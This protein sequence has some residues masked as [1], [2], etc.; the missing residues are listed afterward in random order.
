[1][2]K[3]T[4][5]A[6]ITGIYGQDGSY[7]CEILS[8]LGYLVYG[9][10]KENLSKNSQKIKKYLENKNI[11]PIVYNTDLNNLEELQK[12]LIEINPDE[13]YHLAA[14]HNS[15]ENT[16]DEN[17]SAILN[18]K[19]LYDYNTKS[20][21]NILYIATEFLKSKVVIAGSC[22]MFD[23][24][25]TNIQNENTPFCSK[26][27][28]GLAKISEYELAQYYR[29]KGL[30][31]SCAILYNHESSRRSDDFVTKKIVKNLV[32]IKK[33]EISNFTLGNTDVKK[34]WGYAKDYAYAMYLMLQQNN[35]DNYILST[36]QLHTIK[37]IIKICADYLKIDNVYSYINLDNKIIGRN[38]KGALLGDCSYA[39]N[40]LGFKHSLNF[41]D[42]IELMIKNELNKELEQ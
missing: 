23:N 12:L 20:T 9:I 10:T 36:G 29:K 42:M 30:H 22:L 15:S 27:L 5:K 41:K 6:V 7:L 25:S 35:G 2:E 24:T 13:I 18:E 19:L 33:G 17:K 14:F 11:C 37:D 16:K 34:D 8:K 3:Q 32:K 4:K 31:V 28:Y 1:M 26:S 21:S 40:K 39:K 38:I